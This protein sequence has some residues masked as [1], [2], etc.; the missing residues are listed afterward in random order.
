MSELTKPRYEMTPQGLRSRLEDILVDYATYTRPHFVYKDAIGLGLETRDGKYI[1]IEQSVPGKQPSTHFF[2]EL[3]MNVYPD[4]DAPAYTAF[5]FNQ[6]GDGKLRKQVVSGKEN[7][8][9]EPPLGKRVSNEELFLLAQLTLHHAIE[10]TE[11]MRLE[12]RM[13]VNNQPV[14]PE[15]VVEAMDYLNGAS[16]V[17]EKCRPVA[18]LPWL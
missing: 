11:N 5:N 14:T 13:G 4:A 3:N 18:T 2:Q 7:G 12:E 9:L 10:A 15:D 16:V 1:T 17:D 6:Y 8:V